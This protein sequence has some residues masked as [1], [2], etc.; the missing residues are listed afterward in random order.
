[1]G[2]DKGLLLQAGVPWALYVGRKLMSRM[3]VY[4]SIR[5]AQREAYTA[6]LP[7]E[8]LIP[9]TLDI[10]GPLNGLL[11]VN[12]RMPGSDIL[13]VACDMLDLDEATLGMLIAAWQARGS[14]GPDADFLAYGDE[15]LWQPFCSIY[16]S[17]GLR[18]AT[19]RDSLQSLLRAGPTQPLPI[20]DPAAF[21]NYNSL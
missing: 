10:G 14:S 1:M 16:T 20:T 13:L 6:I 21:A 7:A 3:P 17:R 9:D 19:A 2:R 11:S 18:K 12:R 15:R 8:R 5:P 4:Y